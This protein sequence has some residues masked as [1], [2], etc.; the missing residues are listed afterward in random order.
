MI[1][2]L[3]IS[4]KKNSLSNFAAGFEKKDV[5]IFWTDSGKNAFADIAEKK[6]D[7][8]I[9]DEI[10]NDMTGLDFIKKLVKTNPMV[11]S[12]LISGLSS[13]DF[14]EKTEGFGILMQIPVN[15]DKN[16]AE[17][18]ITNLNGILNMTIS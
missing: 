12:A 8:V 6:F 4:S 2:I 10:F 3:I 18:L 11:N 16:H 1:S 5:N 7:L 17:K 14:H 15:P 13:N 9:S